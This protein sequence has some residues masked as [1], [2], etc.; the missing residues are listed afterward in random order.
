MPRYKLTIEYDGSGF[1][2]WQ[3]QHDMPSIQQAIEEAIEKFGGEKT[4]LHTAGR[5][6]AGVHAFAQ[7][8]HFDLKRDAPPDVVMGAV[9]FHLQP[10]KI[11]LI[12]CEIA[13]DDFHARFNAQKRYYVYRIINRRPPLVLE[14]GRAWFVPVKLDVE[15]MRAG[16]EFMLG[17]HDFTSLRDSECQAKSPLKTLDEIRIEQDGELI[18]IHVSAKSFLHH[19]VRNIVGTLKFVGQGRWK[20]EYVKEVLEAKD[21]SKAGP[22]AP[23]CGLYFVRVEY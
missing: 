23:A 16:A 19:M 14:S 22:T 6:D 20:P 12:Q 8:A 21:R 3:R 9:N 10:A 1:A 11:A 17:L 18:E 2:G 7:V 15:K 13:S 5:T 4:V